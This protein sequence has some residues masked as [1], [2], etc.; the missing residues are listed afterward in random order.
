MAI[1]STKARDVARS[2]Q[3]DLAEVPLVAMRRSWPHHVLLPG[4]RADD[5]SGVAALSTDV[6]ISQWFQ[7]AGTMTGRTR[8]S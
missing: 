3:E 2:D 7:V 1:V 6:G 8:A 4:S 5:E